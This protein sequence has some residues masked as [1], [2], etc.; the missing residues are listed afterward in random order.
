MKCNAISYLLSKAI[1]CWSFFP[2]GYKKA[3]DLIYSAR[4]EKITVKQR[5][6]FIIQVVD[7]SGIWRKKLNQT[8]P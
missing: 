5:N 3:T 6:G 8:T 1:D 4:K 2:F 7:K